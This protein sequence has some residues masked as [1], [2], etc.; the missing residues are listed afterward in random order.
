MAS[1][2][3]TTTR[4]GLNNTQI[5]ALRAQGKTTEEILA[6]SRSQSDQ[7]GTSNSI[8]STQ[9]NSQQA[10]QKQIEASKY[11]T[12]AE[13]IDTISSLPEGSKERSFFEK[14]LAT[15]DGAAGEASEGVGSMTFEATRA[16]QKIQKH[17]A[18]I[19][20]GIKSATSSVASGIREFG[21]GAI[22]AIHDVQGWP[23]ELAEATKP[24]SQALGSSFNTATAIV[25]N[26]LGAPAYLANSLVSIVDKISPGFVDQMDAS[27]KSVNLD[28]LQHLPSK[29]MGSLRNLATAADALLSVPFDILSDMYNG[30]LEIMEAIADL[31]DGLVSSVLNLIQKIIFQILDS[32]LPISE[33]M[34]F[35]DAVGELA[36]FVD[37]IAS[38]AGGFSAVTNITSQISNFSSQFTSV[39]Q[40]PLQLASSFVPQLDQG[41]GM[42][43]QFTGAL[44]NPEQLIGQMLPPEISQQMQNLGQIPGLGFVG[45]LGYSVGD[46]LDGLSKGVFTQALGQFAK[47]APMLGPLFNEQTEPSENAFAQETHKDGYVPGS[48]R[49]DQEVH[50]AAK[51]V[52]ALPPGSTAS[53]KIFAYGITENQTTGEVSGPGFSSN[54][55]QTIAYGIKGPTRQR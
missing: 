45:N 34:S 16:V 22:E 3:T 24:V 9:Q 4:S 50:Q 10:S 48:V 44:R 23:A 37:G 5:Q 29:M 13:I 1:F 38:L 54:N 28:N 36:S 6:I 15:L 51:T 14:L 46:T 26:P 7:L 41:L 20:D 40:N 49:P 33:I 17:S 11:S 8:N 55:V 21:E 43:S 42:V 2:K 25:K 35:L 32:I 12:K 27:F 47:Q 31:I 19:Q 39:L 53:Q 18:Y 52:T 30:L